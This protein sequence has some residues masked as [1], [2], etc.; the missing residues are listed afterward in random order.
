MR[1]LIGKQHEAW[2]LFVK[3]LQS[4]RN[5]SAK[6]LPKLSVEAKTALDSL[7]KHFGKQSPLT[8]IRNEFSFHYKDDN[9]LVEKN[10]QEIPDDEFWH[11]YLSKMRGN[12]FFYASE[13]VVICGVIKLANLNP[14]NAE[15]YVTPVARSFEALQNLIIDVSG[16]IQTLFEECIVV[17]I[18]ENIPNV[19]SEMIELSDAPDLRTIHIPFFVDDTEFKPKPKLE[20]S[21]VG[22]APP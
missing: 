5:M 16:Q 22:A 20:V 3:R 1:A 2:E 4:D 14:E 7:K 10:F 11:F 12:S 9:D 19:Q 17:I 15:P 6:Y 13:L 21:P 8:L 18:K